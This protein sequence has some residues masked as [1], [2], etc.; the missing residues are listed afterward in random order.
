MPPFFPV[1]LFPSAIDLQLHPCSAFEIFFEALIRL[2]RH[3]YQPVCSAFRRICMKSKIVPLILAV[4]VVSSA[5][6]LGACAKKKVAV[7]TPPPPPPAKPTATVSVSHPDI[8]K[9]QSTM[10]TWSTTNADTA[11][12]SGLGTVPATG[13]RTLT[14]ADS[15]TY[16]LMAK[17]PGGE[18]EATARV[19][20]TTPPPVAKAVSPSLQDLFARQVKDVFFDYN[21]YAVRSSDQAAAEATAQFLKDHPDAKI[22]IE[23]HCDERGSEEYNLA[24]GDN[25]ANA[26]RDFLTAQGISKD[27]IKTISYGKEKPFCSAD[28]DQCWQENR[29]AHFVLQQDNMAQ[30]G[31]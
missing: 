17:G 25:R 21:K 23:G 7:S 8:Q 18:A 10:L 29:R 5:L 27:R 26:T 1:S 3:A 28:N 19:T 30:A 24:L 4:L 9:G 13:A 14:P 31:R 2:S 12:I 6:F 16:N 11:T 22:M 15:T 20:V